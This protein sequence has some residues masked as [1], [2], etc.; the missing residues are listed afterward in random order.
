MANLIPE[1]G[2][3]TI[4][5]ELLR[6]KFTGRSRLFFNPD[7]AGGVR[8]NR[9]SLDFSP[10]TLQLDPAVKYRA[11][12]SQTAAN[13]FLQT[14]LI[15]GRGS[16]EN[17]LFFSQGVPLLSYAQ[18]S[19]PNQRFL[20]ATLG[21]DWG[22]RNANAKGVASTGLRLNPNKDSLAFSVSDPIRI[23]DNPYT[24]KIGDLSAPDLKGFKA[25]KELGKYAKELDLKYLG[26]AAGIEKGLPRPV[27]NP[28]RR[29]SDEAY[30]KEHLPRIKEIKTHLGKIA[31]YLT[32]PDVLSAVRTFHQRRTANHNAPPHPLLEFY[33]GFFRSVDDGHLRGIQDQNHGGRYPVT[34][35]PYYEG[36]RDIFDTS[37]ENAKKLK[38]GLKVSIDGMVDSTI[39][40]E[41]I[42]PFDK[43]LTYFPAGDRDGK[44]PSS[45][46]SFTEPTAS[47]LK[48]L[49]KFKKEGSTRYQHGFPQHTAGVMNN[50]H[51]NPHGIEGYATTYRSTDLAAL[52]ESTRKFFDPKS[53][54]TTFALDDTPEHLPFGGFGTE[55]GGNAL[56]GGEFLDSTGQKI[57]PMTPQEG[58]YVDVPPQVKPTLTTALG[59]NLL[60]ITS[61]DE[62][63][64]ASPEGVLRNLNNV[65]EQNIQA[66][67]K[68]TKIKDLSIPNLGLGGAM[69][70][71]LLP[72]TEIIGNYA[73]QETGDTRK[74]Q[75]LAPYIRPQDGHRPA[76]LFQIMDDGTHKVLKQ[77]NNEPTSEGWTPIPTKTLAPEKQ[78]EAYVRYLEEM[79]QSVN[80][81]RTDLVTLKPEIFSEIFNELPQNLTPSQTIEGLKGLTPSQLESVAA[82]LIASQVAPSQII[83][84]KYGNY[85]QYLPSN[86]EY[87]RLGGLVDEATR[88][89]PNYGRKGF[90]AIP[91]FLEKGVGNL[92]LDAKINMHNAN[93]FRT[94]YVENSY[95]RGAVNKYVG[96]QVPKVAAGALAGLHLKSKIDEGMPIAQAVPVTAAEIGIGVAKFKLFDR[97]FGGVTDISPISDTSTAAYREFAAAKKAERAIGEERIRRREAETKAK[98]SSYENSPVSD[99][100]S[101]NPATWMLNG[102]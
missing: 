11:F 2:D 48:Y 84:V 53:F 94:Q 15:A 61:S 93:A 35:P 42:V 4:D 31:D 5:R 43:P 23:A 32:T 33:E 62:P 29:I 80:D 1:S 52:L 78:K 66:W 24:E 85:A 39:S 18:S 81:G 28:D 91:K 37:P 27:I 86:P 56:T 64:F 16:Y 74:W 87:L 72:T 76:V 49:K 60:K 77:Y 75:T 71:E 98:L 69:Y 36:E 25:L 73:D 102:Q 6:D 46:G 21:D 92:V 88:G 7:N 101:H 34:L 70:S 63:N 8:S 50:P 45:F 68:P 10:E 100:P 38:E 14:G 99:W 20:L 47:E 3:G 57:V 40:K 22:D 59:Q 41:W 12:S 58:L 55:G 30:T 19:T 89:N 79:V 51:L 82:R 13:D 97:F 83:D 65:F 96:G 26:K 17:A 90:A 44:Y 95:F 9:R 54:H 67:A